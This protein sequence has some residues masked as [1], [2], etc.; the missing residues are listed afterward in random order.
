MTS[1]ESASLSARLPADGVSS[2]IAKASSN[3]TEI[4]LL[5]PPAASVFGAAWVLPSVSV[6]EV[7]SPLELIRV[8]WTIVEPPPS[9]PESSPPAAV[10]ARLSKSMPEALGSSSAA[11]SRSSRLSASASSALSII[12]S[13]LSR[14]PSASNSSKVSAWSTLSSAPGAR[15]AIRSALIK[16][17]GWPA[18]TNDCPSLKISSTTPPSEVSTDSPS[19]NASPA[20]NNRRSPS[21]FTA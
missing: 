10:A 17:T 5:L 12:C 18:M 4:L 11:V 9:A 8:A 19:N 15:S 13:R 2:E 6:A 1:P 21:A 3:A 20:C 7:S 14:L 16:K